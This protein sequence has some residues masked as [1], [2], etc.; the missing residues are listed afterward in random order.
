MVNKV[1]AYTAANQ[2]KA[3]LQPVSST[4][5]LAVPVTRLSY[6]ARSRACGGK[7]V[8]ASAMLSLMETKRS[9]LCVSA[10]VTSK[11]ELLSLVGSFLVVRNK[12]HT[13]AHIHI[14]IE[15]ASK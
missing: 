9:N 7:N 8:A 5:K 14:Y 1:N 3:S 12:H 6:G 10:D 15:V 2:T 4:P 13:L 11:A